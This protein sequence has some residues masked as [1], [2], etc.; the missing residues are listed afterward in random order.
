MDLLAPI[1]GKN[2]CKPVLQ[3][4][5]GPPR[6]G[7][8]LGKWLLLE[9]GK[10]NGTSFPMPFVSPCWRSHCVCNFRCRGTNVC[11]SSGRPAGPPPPSLPTFPCLVSCRLGSSG[12]NQPAEEAINAVLGRRL[13]S[14]AQ[15]RGRG[16]EPP[17]SLQVASTTSQVCWPLTSEC[18]FCGCFPA[19]RKP[20]VTLLPR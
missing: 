19:L 2:D 9:P 20:V 10:N 4:V 11:N 1:I 8:L 18:T 15:L 16:G 5:V 3:M 6:G 13:P 14:G 7:L 12:R 17:A